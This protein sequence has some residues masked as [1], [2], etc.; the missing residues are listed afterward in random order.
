MKKPN[1]DTCD[2][3]PVCELA[4]KIDQLKTPYFAGY[5]ST[6]MVETSNMHIRV[7]EAIASE[8]QFHRRTQ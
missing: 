4:H 2:H 6:G 7:M 8:C 1:C 5:T 3:G